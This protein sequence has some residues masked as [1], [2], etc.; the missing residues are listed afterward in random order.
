M[1]TNYLLSNWDHNKGGFSIPL[2]ALVNHPDE[3]GQIYER[4]SFFFKWELENI[5]SKKDYWMARRR[6]D[7]RRA[8]FKNGK[9]W[10]YIVNKEFETLDAWAYDCGFYADEIC[11]GT[12]RVYKDCPPVYVTVNELMDAIQRDQFGFLLAMEIG[13]R[14]KKCLAM[15]PDGLIVEGTVYDDSHI[16]RGA[17]GICVTFGG[18]FYYAKSRLPRGVR[19]YLPQPGGGYRVC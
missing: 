12:N 19:V 17:Y 1:T 16:S 13:E 5:L 10:D 8:T 2:Q 11:Y 9:V 7:I 4:P 6:N 3:T 15:Y 14:G 18:E